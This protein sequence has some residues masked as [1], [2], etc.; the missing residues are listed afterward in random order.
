MQSDNFSTEPW[1]CHRTCIS[2]GSALVL[3]GKNEIK[4]FQ[5]PDRFSFAAWRFGTFLAEM[6]LPAHR[7][8]A[9][10]WACAFGACTI[11]CFV[12]HTAKT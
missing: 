9:M 11:N 10:P 5:K 7:A 6:I 2:F 3:F 8:I 4:D 12:A 1:T